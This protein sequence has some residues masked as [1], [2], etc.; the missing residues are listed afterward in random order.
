MSKSEFK[1]LESHCSAIYDFKK[2]TCHDGRVV[3]VAIALE[4][5]KDA[6]VLIQ[7]TQLRPQILVS[8]KKECNKKVLITF[9]LY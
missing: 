9:V 5:V 1:I 3:A 4:L 8:L 2:K 6:I 7:R